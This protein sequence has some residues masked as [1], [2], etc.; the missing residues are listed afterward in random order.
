MRNS[1]PGND[2][3]RDGKQPSPEGIHQD[4]GLWTMIAFIGRKN[5]TPDSSESRIWTKAQPAGPY[6]ETKTPVSDLPAGS[7]CAPGQHWKRQYAFCDGEFLYQVTEESINHI[8]QTI[9]K[10]AETAQLAGSPY[11]SGDH[12]W[13]YENLL[14]NKRLTQKGET[15][16]LLDRNVKH[17]GRDFMA[18][19]PRLE[20]SRE[21][22]TINIRQPYTKEYGSAT[23]AQPDYVEKGADMLG[24]IRRGEWT[25]DSGLTGIMYENVMV[26]DA[27]TEVVV[28]RGGLAGEESTMT[29]LEQAYAESKREVARADELF[30]TQKSSF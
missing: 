2:T 12:R 18:L 30:E 11:N 16:I 26:A 15:V 10:K 8:E 1:Q 27:Q 21:I 20:A 17:E 4:G 5:V 25:R 7:S 3:E 28:D 6:N 9:Q 19:D 22:L 23:A 24:V 29:V 13:S 14:L